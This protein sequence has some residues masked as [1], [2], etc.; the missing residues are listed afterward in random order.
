MKKKCFF[1][2]IIFILI[3]SLSAAKDNDKEI[4]KVSE[5]VIDEIL[6]GLNSND[7][8][9]YSKR[10]D[11]KMKSVSDKNKF[12]HDREKIINWVGR[13][14]SKEYF[15]FINKNNYIIILWKGYFDKKNEDI[16]IMLTLTKINNEYLVSG[17]WFQ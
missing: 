16:L 4:K 2:L 6:K 10:F 1:I 15:G 13:Y 17:L 3:N 7:Y 11:E 9:L 5:Q 12:E 14:A 8:E